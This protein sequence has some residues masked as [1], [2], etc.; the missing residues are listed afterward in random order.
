MIWNEVIQ[1]KS[2]LSNR[3]IDSEY[4]LNAKYLRVNSRRE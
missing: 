4:Q 2:G 3:A 1:E